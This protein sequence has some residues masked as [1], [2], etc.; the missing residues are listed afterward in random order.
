MLGSRIQKGVLFV[1]EILSQPVVLGWDLIPV[2]RIWMKQAVY[3]ICFRLIFIPAPLLP[4]Q[5]EFTSRV[6]ALEKLK[7]A[8]RAS[9]AEMDALLTSLQHRAFRGAL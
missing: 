9:L 2:A 3:F 7:A 6:A 8:H 4:L 1:R 5:Y